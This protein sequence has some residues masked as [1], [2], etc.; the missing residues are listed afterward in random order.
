MIVPSGS[1]RTSPSP[2]PRPGALLGPAVGGRERAVGD[3]A[4][5]VGRALQVDQL[6]LAGRAHAGEVGV[7]A[8]HGDDLVVVA[9]RDGLAPD[10]QVAVPVGVDL[11]EDARLGVGD[12][13]RARCGRRAA[14]RRPGRAGRPS[15]PVVGRHCA[16]HR[17]AGTLPA[18]AAGIATGTHSSRSA[19]ARSDSSCHSP[20]S[21]AMWSTCASV[22]GVRAASVSVS[23]DMRP[24]ACHADGRARRHPA[25][26][27]GR[28][29]LCDKSDSRS[30][31]PAQPGA[32]GPPGARPTG[33]IHGQTG[34]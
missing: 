20:T 8:D 29:I 2:D 26:T 14:R 19:K 4:G 6:E 25:P 3:H 30:V 28:H 27:R 11:A 34:D 12:A 13:Q 1:R 32:T 7:A 22:S 23:A 5:Q 21:R 24:R 31:R 18:S 15:G 16:T 9:H 33:V 10:R 17:K